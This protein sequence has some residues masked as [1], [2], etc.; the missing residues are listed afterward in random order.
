LGRVR[1][2]TEGESDEGEGCFHTESP[3][4]GDHPLESAS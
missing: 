3:G 2:N 4:K 1:L